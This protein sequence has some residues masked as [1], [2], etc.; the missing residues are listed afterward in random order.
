MFRYFSRAVHEISECPVI[1]ALV[2]D[3]AKF[4]PYM[5]PVRWS[6]VPLQDHGAHI[7]AATAIS[8]RLQEA[9][10]MCFVL[11]KHISLGFGTHTEVLVI[12]PIP[13]GIPNPADPMID[14]LSYI[15]SIEQTYFFT[16]TCFSYLTSNCMVLGM[17]GDCL[18]YTSPSP[19][20]S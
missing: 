9:E 6:S 18:L 13:L 16:I 1:L 4:I 15:K 14:R 12:T 5:L 20:D 17:D 3:V 8:D 19:R 2:S 10:T 11:P 7:D